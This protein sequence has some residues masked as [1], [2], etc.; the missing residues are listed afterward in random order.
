[1]HTHTHTHRHT[2]RCNRTATAYL[3]Q[4]KCTYFFICLNIFYLC[5]CYLTYGITYQ[6]TH[7]FGVTEFG[8]QKFIQIFLN[9][10]LVIY[11]YFCIESERNT[12]RQKQM[13]HLFIHY[14]DVFNNQGWL[15]QAESRNSDCRRPISWA[16]ICCL[17]ECAVAAIHI[18]NRT[19]AQIEDLVAQSLILSLLPALTPSIM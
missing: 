7:C 13:L 9:C 10:Y 18:G 4:K 17:S 8:Q 2:Q 16:I 15:G 5:R 12:E 1:M 19:K 6:S 14:P 3:S 11:V